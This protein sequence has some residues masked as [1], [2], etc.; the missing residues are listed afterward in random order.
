MTKGHGG[1]VMVWETKEGVP[2]SAL[3]TIEKCNNCCWFSMATLR[4]D[5]MHHTNQVLTHVWFKKT[6]ALSC[7][8]GCVGC[9]GKLNFQTV[10]L[11]TAGQCVNFFC[12]NY[13]NGMFFWVET[14]GI[15][16]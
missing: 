11:G 8:C 16:E 9:L 13:K 6:G 3:K 7:R 1:S 5:D 14:H 15:L 12:Q 2:H 4:K 10:S